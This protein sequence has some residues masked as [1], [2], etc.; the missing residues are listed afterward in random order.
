MKGNAVDLPLGV[1]ELKC[2]RALRREAQLLECNHYN[3][4]LGSV[5]I[6][7]LKVPLGELRISPD[8]VE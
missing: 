6:S 5:V 3:P 7:Q 2:M 1:G 8:A 4:I